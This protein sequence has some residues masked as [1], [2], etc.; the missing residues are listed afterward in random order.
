MRQRVTVGVADHF[1]ARSGAADEIALACRIA[2]GSLRIPVPGLDVQFRILPI[3]HGLPSGRKNLFD[4]VIYEELV[5]CAVRQ[6]VDAR[7]EGFRR[8]D[9]VRGMIRSDVHMD[10]L[11]AQVRR[12]CDSHEEYRRKA[13]SGQAHTELLKTV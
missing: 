7:A 9:G 8:L 2:P 5:G 1:R 12:Q 13:D 4:S 11:R 6:A 10:A 3:G